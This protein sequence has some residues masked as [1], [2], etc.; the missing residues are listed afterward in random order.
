NNAY[1]DEL[2]PVAHR[3]NGEVVQ[4]ELFTFEN[5]NN[6]NSS[7]SE[8]NKSI[9]NGVANTVDNNWG[10]QIYRVDL[11]ANDSPTHYYDITRSE[12]H[13]IVEL[14]PYTESDEDKE[15]QDMV[16]AR[17]SGRFARISTA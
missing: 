6:Y 2:V 9:F 13:K 3:V 4:G 1:G 10:F 16:G 17:T 11:D 14:Y 7:N 5:Y 12:F 15:G 8:A